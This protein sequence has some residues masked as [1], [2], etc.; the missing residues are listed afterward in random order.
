MG[1]HV[2][3]GDTDGASSMSVI[4]PRAGLTTYLM[5]LPFSS[6]PPSRVMAVV[7]GQTH[8]WGVKF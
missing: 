7:V 1:G 8:G 4:E 6:L 5:G 3:V 2:E